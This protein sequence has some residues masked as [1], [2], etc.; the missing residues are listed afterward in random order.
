MARPA[1]TMEA[2]LAGGE[3]VA[4]PRKRGRLLLVIVTVAVVAG[5]AVGA[6]L[7]LLVLS[8]G[9]A[10]A[11]DPPPV[12]EGA[13]VDVAEMTLNLAGP[14]MHYARLSLAAVLAEKA[15]EGKV[16]LRFPLL[17]DAV[18]SE[19]GTFSAEVLR[20]PEGVEQLR[21][22]LSERAVALYPEGEVLR[23]VFTELV[24]Q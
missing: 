23:I 2:P 1:A 16:Q 20:T 15:D 4:E 6:A 7:Y 10:E 9:E 14:Q 19:V 12:V 17:K 21:Q 24:V 5:V 11:T 3:L 18:I 13:V 22:R 8:G